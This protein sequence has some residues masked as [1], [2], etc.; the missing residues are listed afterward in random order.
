MC[1]GARRSIR[2]K[3]L[4]VTPLT[5]AQARQEVLSRLRARES[6]PAVEE[7]ALEEAAGRVLAEDVAADRDCPPLDRSVRDGYAVRAADVPGKLRLAGEVRAGERGANMVGPGE[8]VEIMTGAPIPAGADAVIMV[9]H[10]TRENGWVSH[11][12][13][14]PSRASSSIR[15]A[16]R[17]PPGRRCCAPASGWTTPISACWRRS[18][19][20]ASRCSASRWSPS[21]PPATKLSKWARRHRN[22]RFAIRTPIRWPRRWPA[23]AACRDACRWRAIP[24]KIR[25]ALVDQGLDTDLLLLSGGVSAGKVRRGGTGAG[26]FRRG[27]L[28]RS[29]AHP[30]GP[31]A[32]LRQRGGAVSFSACRAIPPRPW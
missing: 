29:R 15:E 20:S 14:A 6:R 26:R 21:S 8:A 25:G 12:T 31:A 27:I 16:A 28:F 2:P 11:R 7:A 23:R 30:A 17:P 4:A 3:I 13:G 24:W 10:T 32:G 22:F 18:G 1:L 5:F 9:E 19:A